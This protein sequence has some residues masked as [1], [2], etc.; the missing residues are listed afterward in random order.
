MKNDE[1]APEPNG[2]VICDI[3]ARDDLFEPRLVSLEQIAEATAQLSDATDEPSSTDTVRHYVSVSPASIRL[4]RQSTLPAPKPVNFKAKTSIVEWSAKSRSMMVARLCSLDYLP[5]FADRSRPP[6]MLTLTYPADWEAVVPDGATAKKHLRALQKR[7]ERS[8]SEPLRGVWK[9]EFQRRGAVHFHLFCVPPRGQSFRSWL[10]ENW[11]DI[12]KPA[13]GKASSDHLKA[14]TGVDYASGLRATDPKRIA[15]YFSKHGSAN[16]GDKEYQNRPPEVWV[17][18]GSVGRFWGYW[19]L[20]PLIET[21]EL[22]DASS[23]FLSRTLRR[24]S[25]ANSPARRVV[26]WRTNTKTGEVRKRHAHRRSTRMSG[27]SG[28]VAV[29]DGAR[30]GKALARAL[31]T[32]LSEGSDQTDRAQD[33]RGGS[34]EP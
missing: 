34:L 27:R 15:V 9:M 1:T 12:V 2:L 21:V 33:Q 13:L 8:F 28:F 3:S 20:H 5:L 22:S 17:S 10:S 11:T 32:L 19:G 6:A 26:V 16:Y 24:W 29:N 7:Y 30:M 31:H 25:R 23:L 18:S 14:G 4:S